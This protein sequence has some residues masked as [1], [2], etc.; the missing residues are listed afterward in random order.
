MRNAAEQTVFR[1]LAVLVVSLWAIASAQSFSGTY[2]TGAP[3]V[4]LTLQQDAAGT[5]T[6]ELTG[7]QA[8]FPLEGEVDPQDNNVSYGLVEGTDGYLAFEAYLEG[9]TLYLYLFSISEDG[10]ID[11]D[12]PEEL[13]FSIQGSEQPAEPVAQPPATPQAPSN[14]LAPVT[15]SVP[16]DPFVGTF[17]GETLTVVLQ[18]SGGQ[19][20]GELTFSGQVYPLTATANG[21]NLTGTFQNQGAGFPFN[22]TLDGDTLTVDSGG[23]RFVT[24]REG[25]S[26]TQAPAPGPSPATSII[27]QGQYG[28]LT[29]D[30][31]FAFVEALE[32]SL[33]QMGYHYAFSESEAELV[34]QTLAQNFHYAAPHEQASLS[35]AREI[36]D[37]VQ[38]NWHAAGEADRREFVLGIFTLAFGEQY[39]RQNLGQGGGSGGGGCAD[40]DSCFSQYADPGTFDDTV[41]AQSCWAAAGCESYD[42]V[43]NSFTFDDSSYY[44]E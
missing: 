5:I 34:I 2:T 35:Q 11:F 9:A 44:N 22:A 32:F 18:G 3:G 6:G 29:R 27:A 37:R 1:L 23:S 7:N 31:A 17:I 16:A 26:L 13:V 20:T 33:A 15:P 43:D 39:V 24:V 36:W 21:S 30:G 19:Y 40:I 42:P 25:G 41:G 14:P 4:T 10:Q 12:N 8:R 28:N 38:A